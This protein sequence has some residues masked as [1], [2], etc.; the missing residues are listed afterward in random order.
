MFSNPF[1][2]RPGCLNDLRINELYIPLRDLLL[3]SPGRALRL[4]G[5]AQL[6]VVGHQNTVPGC[7]SATN[8]CAGRHCTPPLQ[9]VDEFMLA[10][11]RSVCVIII[12]AIFTIF[13]FLSLSLFN[14]LSSGVLSVTCP[15]ANPRCRARR[16]PRSAPRVRVNV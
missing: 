10:Q 4:D 9:C 3:T 7:Q 12:L 2:P 8:P 16:P 11:C 15:R 13:L 14:Y 5:G 6:V 1:V